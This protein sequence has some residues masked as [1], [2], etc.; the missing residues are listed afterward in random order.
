MK[1]FLLLPAIAFV[2]AMNLS[3]VNADI[4]ASFDF[5]GGSTAGLTQGAGISGFTA[6]S[7]ALRIDG[8]QT[9]VSINHGNLNGALTRAIANDDFVSF[10]VAISAAEEFDFT[11]IALD[12][13]A[14]APSDFAVGIFSSLTGFTAG[15][16]IA[17][18]FENNF[19][20]NFSSFADPIDL[21]GLAALQGLTDTTV[22]FRIYLSDF[23][24]A[25]SR[26]HELD[27]I[28]VSA[29]VVTTAVP[30]PS[31]MALLGLGGI[32]L[33]ARRRK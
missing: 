28:S 8:S 13:N 29:D 16:V 26:I 7:E 21:S 33:L 23:S 30:E 19:S 9:S 22:E 25:T 32:A 20:G 15:D 14:I 12:Y 27:N 1:S 3:A 18:D 5:T 2:A 4:V 11:E 17:G 24:S 31:S 6:V 10:D